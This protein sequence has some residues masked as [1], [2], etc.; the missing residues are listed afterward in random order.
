MVIMKQYEKGGPAPVISAN[1]TEKK[2][3]GL[4]RQVKDLTV[5]VSDQQKELDRMHRDIV[6]LRVTINDL[7]AKIKN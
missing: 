1:D 5:R 3:L 6:R 7:S 2:E 4:K